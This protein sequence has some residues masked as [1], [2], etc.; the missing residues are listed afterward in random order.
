MSSNWHRDLLE[1]IERLQFALRK[2]AGE[3]DCGITIDD[4]I[5]DSYLNE[6]DMD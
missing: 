6:G 4:L 2:V 5:Q 3:N 1:Q